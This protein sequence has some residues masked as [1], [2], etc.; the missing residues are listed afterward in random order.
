MPRQPLAP[1]TLFSLLAIMPQRSFSVLN[2]IDIL[3]SQVVVKGRRVGTA[4]LPV[5]DTA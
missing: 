5:L 3:N 2:G 4:G 1:K